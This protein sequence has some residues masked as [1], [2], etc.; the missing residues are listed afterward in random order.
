MALMR[1]KLYMQQ[2]HN[3]VC[4]TQHKV[5]P[6]LQQICTQDNQDLTAVT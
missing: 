2:Q 3:T 6:M 5:L 4:L 1:I